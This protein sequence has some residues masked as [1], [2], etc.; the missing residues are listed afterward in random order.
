MI[1][2]LVRRN[3]ASNK[4]RL[5]L[6]LLSVVI[7]VAF[8]SG[9]FL[10][11]D[12]LRSI[13]NGI[14]EQ[15]FAGVDA[16]V[17]A[18]QDELSDTNV[19]ERFDDSV[20]ATVSGVPEVEFAEGA[21]FAFEQVYTINDDGEPRRPFGPPVLSSSWAGPSP[22]SSWNIVDGRAPVGLEM[23]IDTT[24]AEQF[25][26]NVGDI[27][28]VGLSDG[29]LEEF[30]IVGTVT[31]GDAAA[32]AFFN[33]FDL[34]TMQR[35]VG[36]EGL[37]DG[38]AISA[39]DGVSGA[40]LISSVEQALDFD[41][42]YEVV[43]SA[44]LVEESNDSFGFIIDIIGY[45]LLGFA[46]AVVFVSIFIIYNT[47]A[48]LISQRIRQFGL[49]RSVGTTGEQIRTMVLIEA[50]LI[51]LLASVIGLFGGI[52]IAWLL[53]LLFST[54]GGAFPD[55]PIIFE[56]R[57]IVWAFAIGVGVTV[58][59]ALIPAVLS[60]RIP[61]L[62]ALRD[63]AQASEGSLRRRTILGVL[64]TIA[65][66]AALGIG[67]SDLDS[68]GLRWSL[69]GLGTVLLFVGVA[70]LSALFAGRVAHLIGAPVE[71][72]RGLRGRLA[73][74]NATRNP[75][76]TAATATA[77]MI[78]LAL[79]AAVL[80]IQ[81]SLRTSLNNVLNDSVAAD[82]FIFE[83]LQGL[84]FA[85]TAA[86]RLREAPEIAQVAGVSALKGFVDGDVVSMAGFDVSTGESVL[87]I[88]LTEGTYNLGTNG[89]L[90]LDDTAAELNK[91]IGDQVE[92]VFP[93]DFTDTFSIAGLFSDTTLVGADWVLDREV[94]RLHTELDS[95]GF[96]GATFAEG[97]DPDV[98]QEAATEAISSFPQL[99]VQDNT[100]FRETQSSQ[101]NQILILIFGLLMLCVVVAL[102]GIINTMVLSVLERTREIGLLRAVGTSRKQL[103]SMIRWEAIIVGVF[104]ALMGVVLG[105]IIGVVFSRAIP[106]QV[107]STITIPWPWLALLLLVGAL[108]GAGAALLPA[109]RA[110]KMNILDAIS[111]E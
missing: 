107:I 23:A 6:M 31:F 48:I 59:S 43:S 77:L 19:L 8:V 65:A 55:G 90:L 78:G 70:A 69:L 86:E 74:D 88:G 45:I 76:R 7:G 84:P 26:L 72:T 101:V 102:I 53:K 36:A 27:T 73:R 56:P 82:L 104:G 4:G 66:V 11:A 18:T 28:L 14:S 92:I 40:E 41:P 51:G 44:T 98:A 22:V 64:F 67:S 97:V 32:G 96:L 79:V 106:D 9:S 49:L 12:S 71:A 103:R 95:V 68:E 1:L 37:V 83:E 25:D 34:P 13:F 35:I 87:N 75:R 42:L 10:L 63:G 39:A 80:V 94:T 108:L 47:F 5:A 21:I 110:A 24:Q 46:L 17:R 58:L 16:Q 81:Q 60:Q 99:I 89:V 54:G 3:I 62:A 100:E 85:G 15:A 30:E 57:T 38:V 91:T 29:S 2:K 33:L 52:G 111:A 50:L 93:D 20:V 105:L 109:R 61:A